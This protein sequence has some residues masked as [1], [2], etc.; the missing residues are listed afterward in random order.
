MVNAVTNTSLTHTI[1]AIDTKRASVDSI[2]PLSPGERRFSLTANAVT[3]TASIEGGPK[4]LEPV[5][6]RDKN[7]DLNK[8]NRDELIEGL[9]SRRVSIDSTHELHEREALIE[10]PITKKEVEK[11]DALV[12]GVKTQMSTTKKPASDND[13][14]AKIAETAIHKTLE[15]DSQQAYQL[16]TFQKL[17]EFIFVVNS[18]PEGKKQLSSW[19]GNKY[20]HYT[21]KEPSM[22]GYKGNSSSPADAINLVMAR[23]NQDLGSGSGKL[24]V[25]TMRD[26]SALSTQIAAQFKPN[27]KALVQLDNMIAL[28]EGNQDSESTALKFI[29]DRLGNIASKLNE[30]RENKIQTGNAADDVKELIKDQLLN[31]GVLD[32]EI[33]KLIN[34]CYKDILADSDFKSL[35]QTELRYPLKGAKM[36][37]QDRIPK[38]NRLDT[39]KAVWGPASSARNAGATHTK[40]FSEESNKM[41]DGAFEAVTLAEMSDAKYPQSGFGSSLTTWHTTQFLDVVLGATNEQKKVYAAGQASDWAANSASIFNKYGVQGAHGLPEAFLTYALSSTGHVTEDQLVSDENAGIGKEYMRTTLIR[42]ILKMNMEVTPSQDGKSWELTAHP[43]TA[44]DVEGDYLKTR[45]GDLEE[46]L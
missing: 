46:A 45:K 37:D 13:A 1:Q 39:A 27:T 21:N 26:I 8:T 42:S 11:F 16:A 44:A 41:G 5:E 36:W 6:Y 38:E 43:R 32:S 24:T 31:K 15:S 14:I 10:S 3:V 29:D 12:T 4:H 40:A 23:V 25:Q 30:P 9:T 20:A 19:G 34:D 35:S 28:L 7:K 18:T 22:V 17:L 33:I 2:N